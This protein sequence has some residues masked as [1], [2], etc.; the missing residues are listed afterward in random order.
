MNVSCPTN[1][2]VMI[3]KPSA[4]NGASSAAGR[5]TTASGPL[6]GSNPMMG[7]TSMGDGR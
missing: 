7:G 4:E 5:S 6:F 2:S 1:G 3:L